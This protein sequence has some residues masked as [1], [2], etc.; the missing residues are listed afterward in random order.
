MMKK[1]T[2]LF[3]TVAA[4]LLLCGLTGCST[5]TGGG[6][7]GAMGNTGST[8]Q[9]NSGTPAYAGFPDVL[10]PAELKEESQKSYL[11]QSHALSAGVLS[12]KGRVDRGSIIAFF[13]DNMK[14]DNWQAIGSFTSARSILLF[15]KENRW[16][17]INIT[18]GDFY[19]YVEIGVVPKSGDNPM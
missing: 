8:I 15:Q 17:V 19:T 2:N 7:G 18:E 3:L 10:I 5:L 13:R 11:V 4:V 6:Q 16:C 14:K 12:F 1:K 9:D